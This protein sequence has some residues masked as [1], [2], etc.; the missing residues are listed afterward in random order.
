MKFLVANTSVDGGPHQNKSLIC[1]PMKTPGVHVSRKIEKL[2]MHSSDTAQIF[3]EDVR[4]PAK[5]IIG[6]KG[7]DYYFI[8]GLGINIIILVCIE[9]KNMGKGTGYPS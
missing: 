7:L 9:G 1:V 3:F 6:E 5:Y 8:R 2:G 4:V